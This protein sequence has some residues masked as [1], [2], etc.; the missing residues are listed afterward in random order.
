MQAAMIRMGD[1]KD[2]DVAISSDNDK[3]NSQRLL[4][5]HFPALEAPAPAV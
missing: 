4:L 2:V 3:L 5:L 1:T